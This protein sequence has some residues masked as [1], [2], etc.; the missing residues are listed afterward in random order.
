ME[1]H[2]VQRQHWEAGVLY[3]HDIP[4][5]FEARPVLP[6]AHSY[7]WSAPNGLTGMNIV[8][9]NRATEEHRLRDLGKLLESWSRDGWTYEEIER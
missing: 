2:S 5:S 4:Q 6:N 9:L 7:R 8:F 3:T 1:D